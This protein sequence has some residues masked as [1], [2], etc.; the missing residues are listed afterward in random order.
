MPT[1]QA[2]EFNPSDFIFGKGTLIIDEWLQSRVD[3]HGNSPSPFFIRVFGGGSAEAPP[4][5][6]ASALPRRREVPPCSLISN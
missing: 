4:Q 5:V 6:E 1:F 3:A 2:F